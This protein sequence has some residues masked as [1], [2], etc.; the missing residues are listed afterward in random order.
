[1][2]LGFSSV[3]LNGLIPS[4]YSRHKYVVGPRTDKK[5]NP[6]TRPAKKLFLAL[7]RMEQSVTK[8]SGSN[9]SQRNCCVW[10]ITYFRMCIR[11]NTY[12]S[13]LCSRD[14]TIFQCHGVAILEANIV[15]SRT[16]GSAQSLIFFRSSRK[17][18]EHSS[19]VVLSDVRVS[20]VAMHA[21]K[22]KFKSGLAGFQYRSPV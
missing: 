10:E 7:N 1:M 20:G 18:S 17:P 5:G 2:W 16:T 11:T 22:A 8:I 19:N 13:S 4:L 9:F 12:L 21:L 6:H 14:N 15:F 3:S